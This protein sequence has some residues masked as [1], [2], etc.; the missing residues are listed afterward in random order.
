MLRNKFLA[1]MIRRFKALSREVTKLLIE[2]DA[3][4]LVVGRPLQIEM[5]IEKQ[6]WRFQTNPQKVTSF[7]SWL[8]NQVQT[9]I[10][11]TEGG[12]TSRPWTAQYVESSY[13][14]GVVRAYTD[15]RKEQLLQSAEVFE[16]TKEQFLRSSF[17]G[18]ESLQKIELLYQ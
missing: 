5:N 6:A 2:D 11:T 18:S 15:Y 14:K 13:K 9:G 1:D 16:G 8:N 4:G 7:R 10:L 12:I 3:L 17:S